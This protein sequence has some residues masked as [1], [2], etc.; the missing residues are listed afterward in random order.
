VSDINYSTRTVVR[1]YQGRSIFSR[2][3]IKEGRR[4]AGKQYGMDS[5]LKRYFWT[6]FTRLTGYFLFRVNSLMELTLYNPPDGG[7]QLL[8]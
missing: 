3:L 1:L 8:Q 2:R 5:I 7:K 6:G 4:E